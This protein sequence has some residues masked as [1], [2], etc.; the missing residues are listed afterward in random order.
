MGFL[1][2]HCIPSLVLGYMHCELSF[3][4]ILRHEVFLLCFEENE[5]DTFQN[6]S[7]K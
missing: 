3:Q 1:M 2:S 6:K 5:I 7:L 4:T